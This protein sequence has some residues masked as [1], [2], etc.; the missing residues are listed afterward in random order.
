MWTSLPLWGFFC[1]CLCLPIELRPELPSAL[2]QACARTHTALSNPLITVEV[3]RQ[4]L[5]LWENSE[6]I[7]IY[8]I[9]TALN[10]IGSL[11][12][13]GQTPIG[14]HRICKKIGGKTP[15]YSIFKSRKYTGI[16]WDPKKDKA[17]TESDDLILSRILRLEGLE[18]GVNQGNN[19]KGQ[20]VDSYERY[21]YIHGTNHESALGTP[22]SQGCIRMHSEEICSLFLEVTE[23]TLV[24]IA[25]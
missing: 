8:T 11:N 13:S 17:S 5:T 3:H 1:C 9:S 20:C 2:L 14:L 12:G 18:F 4:T 22:C 24:W 15:L 25:P 21:I 16:N 23:D 10:G 7:R 19:T 6:P